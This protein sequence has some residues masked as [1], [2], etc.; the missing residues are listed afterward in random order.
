MD[1][2]LLQGFIKQAEG[3][4]PTIRGGILVCAQEGNL[5]GELH[6][7]VR[8]VESIKS[9]ASIIGLDDV[10]QVGAELEKKLKKSVSKKEPLADE[11]ARQLLDKLTELEVLLTKIHFSIDD[12]SEDVADFIEESFENLQIN[13]PAE[14]IVEPIETLEETEETEEEFE[15]DDEML[16][17]FT[18]EA[19]DIV[20]AIN[21]NLEILGKTPN[22]R[23]ALLEIRRNAHTLKGSAGIVGLKQ[24]SDLAHRVEDLLDHLA[25]NEIESNEKIFELLLTST[26]CFEALGRSEN[27]AQLTKKIALTYQNFDKIMASL[28]GDETPTNTPLLENTPDDEEIPDSESNPKSK[29]QSPKSVV[30]VSLE[31]LDDLVNIVSGL[32]ISRSVFE[33]RLAE[34]D[35]QIEELHHSTL[36]LQ[37]S[38]TKL[39][40]D[41]SADLLA[42]QS[43]NSRFQIPDSRFS[44]SQL[45]TL[46]SQ[47]FDTL[48][49]DRYT[50]LHQTTRELIET[51]TD[52]SAISSELHNLKGNLDL[53]FENQRRLID[54]MQEKL[55][56]LR[57]VSFGSLAIRLQRTVRVISEEEDKSVELFIEGENLEVD[58]Q[59]LDALIEPLLHLLRN[60]VA[61]GIEPPETR[62]ILGKPEY[63][64]IVVR[65]ASE[66]THISLTVSDDG[67]GISA[68]S[69]KNKAVNNGFISAEKAALM[70]D[71]EAFELAFLPGLTTAEKLS[72]VSGRGVGLNI[73]KNGIAR[74]QGA[75]LIDAELQKG[76]T[77][78]IRLPMALAVTRAILV[79][80][81]QQTFAFPLKLVK[82]IA[83]I[84]AKHLKKDNKSLQFGDVHYKCSH[85]NELLDMSVNAVSN[86]PNIPVLLLDTLE[87]PC[88][89]IVD[90][91][92]KTEEIVIKPLGN[93]LQNLRE[94]LGATIL[95]DGS[96]VPVLDVVYLLKNVKSQK[97]QVP[98]SNAP[99]TRD[100]ELKTKNKELTIM[101]V[102]DSPSVRQLTSNIVKNAGWTAIIAKDGLEALEILQEIGKPPDIILTDVEM[103]RMNGYDLL[104]SMKQQENLKTIPV[105]MITSRSSHKHRQKGVDLGV[106]DYLAKPFDDKKLIDIIKN[107]TQSS[108]L[109]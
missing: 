69:L 97:P 3:Y 78:T 107:L 98:N 82:H 17:I 13:L 27:S 4:L 40:T 71:G 87:S 43:P 30:R 83:D 8:E 79:K 108:S 48:E 42:I 33:Q 60:A 72:Q 70:T 58:T 22:N 80:A 46:N 51:T 35:R 47:L 102:D 96:I 104:A 85:L 93:P 55:L 74:Q 57:M 94:L 23:E 65:L 84:S 62:R 106:S 73:V 25:E 20:R 26:D 77:F 63:G 56:R 99:Q 49:F 19:E 76:T 64:K 9:A 53:L 59:I 34:F 86:N 90:E 89:L 37:R 75:I 81:N 61:H 31:K 103:P 68:S 6:T 52:T 2:E 100:K 12:S 18:L 29:I 14:E 38:T 67:R 92:I 50:E 54:E 16:E 15:I 32:I 5:Y 28:I 91:I 66:G 88:A 101:I 95:G 11:E 44:S 41:S 1:T 109:R 24:L 45:T 36:R 105:V 7:A 21:A 10:A 39:E